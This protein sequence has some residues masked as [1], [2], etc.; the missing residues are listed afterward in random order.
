MKVKVPFNRDV[1]PPPSY[2]ASI[3]LEADSIIE[4]AQQF[5]DEHTS[6]DDKLVNAMRDCDDESQVLDFEPHL[7]TRPCDSHI[8]V[9]TERFVYYIDISPNYGEPDYNL[10]GISRTPTGFIEKAR[11][12]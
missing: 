12:A 7:E 10:A 8:T 1:Y 2:D 4:L 11:N 9:W 3:T 5:I 6:C